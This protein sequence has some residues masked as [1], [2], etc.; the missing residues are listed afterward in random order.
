MSRSVGRPPLADV[1]ATH[2]LR[3]R[4]TA[5]QLEQWHAAA[6]RE[7]RSLSD[8]VRELLGKRWRARRGMRT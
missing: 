2:Q 3:V 5:E 6:A 1:A 8:I 4:A 7:G